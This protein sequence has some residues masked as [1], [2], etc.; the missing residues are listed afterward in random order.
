MREI[1]LDTE[2]TGLNPANGDRIIEIGMVELINHLP[3]GRNWH[4]YI[5]PERDV[6]AEAVAVHGLTNEFLAD[7]PLFSTM[8]ESF[9]EFMGDATLVIHNAAFDVGFLNAELGY[10]K[11]AAIQSDRVID[12]LLIARQKYPMGPNSLDAL[13]KRYGVNNS[14]RSKHGALLDCQLLAEV[15][16]ELIGA[17]QPNLNLIEKRAQPK[18][19]G[20]LTAGPVKSRTTTLPSRLTE[21][22]KSAHAIAVE[23]L[24]SNNLWARKIT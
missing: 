9:L 1:V 3:S 17:R 15:Y 10:L 5:N 24:G 12:T 7:K 22:E 23:E 2:T 14:A 13:C 16:I 20:T 18:P 8:A 19:S 6:S 4:S 11:K 21:A